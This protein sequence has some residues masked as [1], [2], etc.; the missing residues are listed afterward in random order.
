MENIKGDDVV[1]MRRVG[2][3][4]LLEEGENKVDV[5]AVP[6]VEFAL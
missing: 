3:G 1:W 4:D 5:L 2:C 6:I